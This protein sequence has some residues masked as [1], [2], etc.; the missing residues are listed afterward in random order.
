MN[1]ENKTRSEDKTIS[2]GHLLI[3]IGYALS[4]LN[5]KDQIRLTQV[6]EKECYLI[7]ENYERP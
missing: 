5:A 3:R 1:P 7:S 4:D 6:I 2:L